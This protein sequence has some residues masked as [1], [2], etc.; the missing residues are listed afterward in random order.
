VK[1]VTDLEC[2]EWFRK[3]N[4]DGVFINGGRVVLA[5]G[6]T[7]PFMRATWYRLIARGMIE[8]YGNGNKRIR[9]KNDASI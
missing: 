6:E 9:I 5:G 4:G 8:R 7:G 2:L 3:H 1:H